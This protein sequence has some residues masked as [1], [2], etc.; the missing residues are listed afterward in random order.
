M[1]AF[2]D[3]VQPFLGKFSNAEKSTN[4]LKNK[5]LVDEFILAIDVFNTDIEIL[6]KFG[7]LKAELQLKGMPLADAD[8]FIAATC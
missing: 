7:A 5:H 8:I 1:F 4:R 2:Q 3:H 6:T